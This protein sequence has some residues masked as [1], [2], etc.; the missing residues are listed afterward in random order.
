[1]EDYMNLSLFW[2]HYVSHKEEKSEL[3]DSLIKASQ[4]Q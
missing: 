1:M 4:Q 2:S 3:V